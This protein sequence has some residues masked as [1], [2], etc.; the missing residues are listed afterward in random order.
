MNFSG[1]QSGASLASEGFS[2][3]HDYW[4]RLWSNRGGLP[5]KG[6]F[7]PLEASAL[8]GYLAWAEI[9]REPFRVRYRMVGTAL[10]D[11]A[12]GEMTGKY[13]DELYSP[14][15]RK[16]LLNAFRR[17]SETGEPHVDET[18]VAWP[19][20]LHV[21]WILLPFCANEDTQPVDDAQGV[22]KPS[23]SFVLIAIR[24]QSSRIRKLHDWAIDVSVSTTRR[25]FGHR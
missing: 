25:W 2:Q 13:V 9:E 22:P 7:D 12:G 20:S 3:L 21:S 4:F 8:L 16:D 14:A 1:P 10:N 19:L 11:L 15:I 18:G 5:R 6:D 24:P 17:V 23:V